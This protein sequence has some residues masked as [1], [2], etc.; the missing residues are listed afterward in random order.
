VPADRFAAPGAGI[1]QH[2]IAAYP[3]AYDAGKALHAAGKWVGE[4]GFGAMGRARGAGFRRAIWWRP[5]L[6]K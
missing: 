3:I 4:F 2:G 5:L 1:P 6:L